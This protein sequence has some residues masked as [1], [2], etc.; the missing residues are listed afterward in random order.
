[1]PSIRVRI[2]EPDSSSTTTAAEVETSNGTM[3][4]VTFE[5]STLAGVK[6]RYRGAKREIIVRSPR[7]HELAGHM[8]EPEVR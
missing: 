5:G 6:L 3:E 7:E 2:S 4:T 1:M 8:L